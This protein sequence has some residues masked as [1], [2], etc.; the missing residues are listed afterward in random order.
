MQL[1]FSIYAN[2]LFSYEAMPVSSTY[3]PSSPNQSWKYLH[4]MVCLISM[5]CVVLAYVAFL[6]CSFFYYY[7]FF[8]GFSSSLWLA[9]NLSSVC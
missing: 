4:G 1:V 8:F 2:L 6:D 5:S 3:S 9:M 7:Y